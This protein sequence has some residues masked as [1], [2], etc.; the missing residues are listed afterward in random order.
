MI[1]RQ[2]KTVIEKN[3]LVFVPRSG[4]WPDGSLKHCYCSTCAERHH[5]KVNYNATFNDG[6]I[7]NE[8]K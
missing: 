3:A 5:W 8:Y 1:C 2:C 4:L 7:L 6:N